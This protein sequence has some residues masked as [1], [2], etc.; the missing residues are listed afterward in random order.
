MSIQLQFLWIF[1]NVL[2][3]ILSSYF[4]LFQAHDVQIWTVYMV[5]G[6][7][8]WHLNINIIAHIHNFIDIYNIISYYLFDTACHG[9]LENDHEDPRVSQGSRYHSYWQWYH[10]LDWIIWPSWWSPVLRKIIFI[11]FLPC[12][13]SYYPVFKQMDYNCTIFN[14]Y[15]LLNTWRQEK[16]KMSWRQ[17]LS[18][19]MY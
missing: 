12:Y 18:I 9:G 13:P 6:T 17:I 1:W 14:Q 19:Y 10:F 15:L 3:I 2:I 7:C 8:I 5:T 16:W 4:Y 11:Q